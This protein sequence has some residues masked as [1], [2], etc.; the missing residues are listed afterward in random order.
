MD[1]YSDL[2]PRV[3][4][5]NSPSSLVKS[6]LGSWNYNSEPEI[7]QAKLSDKFPT[8]LQKKAQNTGHFMHQLKQQQL[9]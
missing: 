6:A 1:W 4:W 9:V 8:L 3:R 5:K 2:V 7:D